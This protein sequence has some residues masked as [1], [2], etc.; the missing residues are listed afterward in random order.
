MQTSVTFL[1]HI[2]N[3][4]GVDTA[5]YLVPR[6]GLCYLITLR[7]RLQSPAGRAKLLNVL[8]EHFRH[9]SVA[10]T[11]G[12]C[13][14]LRRALVTNSITE[15]LPILVECVSFGVCYSAQCPVLVYVQVDEMDLSRTY[16]AAAL[17][18][19]AVLKMRT[20]LGQVLCW[21]SAGVT[22][23][24]EVSVGIRRT[25]RQSRLR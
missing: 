8:I 3:T 23:C 25:P 6:A 24:L 19:F 1:Q 11:A 2:W 16:S 9:L 15:F 5:D 4:W 22:V 7:K 10:V 21:T 17:R 18:I 20:L 13:N 14:Q 12:D